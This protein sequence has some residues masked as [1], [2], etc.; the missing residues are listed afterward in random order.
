MNLTPIFKQHVN[1]PW[2]Q[3][4]TILLTRYGS[5]AYGTDTP[6]SDEDFKGCAIPPAVYF[7]GFSKKF[8]QAES[9]DPD[10]VIYDI[11]KF[12]GLAADCNPSLI[13]V[14]FA[15][16]RDI[17][18]VKS[19]GY[20]LLESRDLFLSKKAKHTFSGYAHSQLKRI[21]GH[22]AWLRNPPTKEPVRADFG[23]PEFTVIPKDQLAAAKAAVAKKMAG[24]NLD[25]D[26]TD[27]ALRIHV[28]RQITDYL[29]EISVTSD[30][31]WVNAGRSIGIGDNFLELME[32]ERRY[33]NARTNWEQYQNWKASR[34]PA[35]AA[36]EAQHGY[37]TK[38]GMHLVR[39]MRMGYE[40]L[41][42]GKVMVKRPD[43]EELRHIRAGG[44]S[45]EQLIEFTAQADAQ[46]EAA[47][48]DS[49]LPNTP[50]RTRLDNLCAAL[51]EDRLKMF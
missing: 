11:R 36:L 42:T 7:H 1:M 12:C 39:L 10:C 6:E 49:K 34:N 41:A 17:V 25:L 47:Y 8:E 22:H 20:R 44:W 14:L 32:L 50:D 51:V 16:D 23:L 45:Y 46:I 3:A 15:D 5:K 40:I 19:S 27:P 37:D 21:Q 43:A 4:G 30:N 33:Q 48:R 13:E 35:R 18:E 28:E 31:A 38:H 2:L 24:W 29:A 9:K 26:G